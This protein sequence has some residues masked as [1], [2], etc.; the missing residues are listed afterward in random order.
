MDK[1]DDLQTGLIFKI[2]FDSG[3]DDERKTKKIIK[4]AEKKLRRA[5]LDKLGG[6]IGEC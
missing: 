3:I 4:S 2:D 1:I 6:R 5:F